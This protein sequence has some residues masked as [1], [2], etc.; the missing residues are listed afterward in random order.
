VV[1][2]GDI[3]GTVVVTAEIQKTL[4]LLMLRVEVVREGTAATVGMREILIP[5]TPRPDLEGV[6]EAEALVALRMQQVLV[7]V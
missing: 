6:V 1:L 5:I 7:V 3:Q 2:V 4:Q